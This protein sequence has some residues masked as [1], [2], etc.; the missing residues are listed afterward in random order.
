MGERLEPPRVFEEARGIPDISSLLPNLR[1]WR[2]AVPPAW[3]GNIRHDRTPS[4]STRTVRA[5]IYHA[6][7]PDG[8]RSGE[9]T[10][11][12]LSDRDLG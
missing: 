8:R 2:T 9:S 11:A 10:S 12:S 7:I 1:S 6:L 4:P 5:H 3:T